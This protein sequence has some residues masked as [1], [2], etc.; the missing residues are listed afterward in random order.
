MILRQFVPF[1][2]YMPKNFPSRF[3]K[4]KSIFAYNNLNK[5]YNLHIRNLNIH[6]YS[7]DFNT[8]RKDVNSKEGGK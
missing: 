3:I 8:N 2:L 6:N 7:Y 4:C 1:L 5:N